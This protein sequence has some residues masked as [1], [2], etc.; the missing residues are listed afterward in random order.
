[1]SDLF[2]GLPTILGDVE[3]R[4]DAEPVVQLRWLSDRMAIAAAPGTQWR[5]SE[6][7]TWTGTRV[8]IDSSDP[9]E[10]ATVTPRWGGSAV[11]QTRT[12][13]YLWNGLTEW[14]ELAPAAQVPWL[15]GVLGRIPAERIVSLAPEVATIW[16]YPRDL[17]DA[18][19]LLA[20]G[21]YLR[22]IAVNPHPD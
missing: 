6:V 14:S 13:K 9:S 12:T 4:L 11:L 10:R 3:L 17:R 22:G 19:L 20:L 8:V 5:F 15:W 1:M 16:R 18:H 21:T 2:T 7:P